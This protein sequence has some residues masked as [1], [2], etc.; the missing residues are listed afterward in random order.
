MHIYVYTIPNLEKI[1]VLL[2]W[3]SSLSERVFKEIKHNFG[4]YMYVF[5]WNTL[6]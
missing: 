3:G 1:L 4:D 6:S 2:K 5:I